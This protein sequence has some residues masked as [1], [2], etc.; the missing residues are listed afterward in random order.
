MRNE[1]INQNTAAVVKV[2]VSYIH[3][4]VSLKESQDWGLEATDH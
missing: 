2:A 3:Y 4:S 1:I